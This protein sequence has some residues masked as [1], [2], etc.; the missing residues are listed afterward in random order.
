MINIITMLSGK[1]IKSHIF[2]QRTNTN[3]CC[4]KLFND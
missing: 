3:W 4:A 1:K 2:N